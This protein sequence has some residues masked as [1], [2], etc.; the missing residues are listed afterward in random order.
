MPEKQPEYR[1]G[2]AHELFLMNLAATDIEIKDRL[3][4]EWRASEEERSWLEE[5][6]RRLV[7]EKYTTMEWLRR[8]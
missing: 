8:R 5:E 6:V 4:A 3:R 2:R 7:K 1:A